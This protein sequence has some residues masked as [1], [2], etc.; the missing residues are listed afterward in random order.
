MSKLTSNAAKMIIAGSNKGIS[1][2]DLASNPHEKSLE[3]GF[4]LN[5]SEEQSIK[6]IINTPFAKTVHK[7]DNEVINYF[8]KV[9]EDGRYVEKSFSSPLE[10]STKL[11]LSLKED[12]ITLI[13]KIPV[14]DIINVD[15]D[16]TSIVNIL[17]TGGILLVIAGCIKYC[18]AGNDFPNRPPV[19][20]LS[21]VEKP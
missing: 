6:D 12:S 14:E 10:V 5:V 16:S 19:I 13:P 3:L 11:G 2:D 8:H 20:D 21:G 7:Y 18:D 17:I 15:D 4:N 9:I 1:I